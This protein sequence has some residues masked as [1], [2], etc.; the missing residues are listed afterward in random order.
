MVS[1]E[2]RQMQAHASDHTGSSGGGTAGENPSAAEFLRE[3]QFF[4]SDH[5]ARSGKRWDS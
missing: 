1:Q 3:L 4:S 2:L 5:R